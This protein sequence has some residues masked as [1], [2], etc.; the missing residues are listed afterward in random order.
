MWFWNQWFQGITGSRESLI[1]HI[2]A[3]F[4][5]SCEIVKILIRH[6]FNVNAK[7]FDGITPLHLAAHKGFVKITRTLIDNGT[8]IDSQTNEKK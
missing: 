5:N 3:V 8:E 1:P 4:K 2:W 6:G 7:T